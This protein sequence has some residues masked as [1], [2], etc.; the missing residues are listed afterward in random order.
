MIITL[1]ARR[2]SY[3]GSLPGGAKTFLVSEASNPDLGQ[4]QPPIHYAPGP[5]P[6]A[7]K[8][9]VREADST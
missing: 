3:R 7:A 8:R 5:L 6:P 2:P 1:Q 4:N 9:Q